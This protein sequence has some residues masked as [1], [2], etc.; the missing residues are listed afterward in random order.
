MTINEK[1]ISMFRNLQRDVG[2]SV[3]IAADPSANRY[4]PQSAPGF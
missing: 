4:F 1:T 3:A 2:M